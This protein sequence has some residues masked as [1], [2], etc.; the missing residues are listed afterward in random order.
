MKENKKRKYEKPVFK[1]EKG[2]N[3]PKEII[4]SLGHSMLC[5]QCSSCHGCQ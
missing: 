3:F 5:V 4:N 2:M 1:K